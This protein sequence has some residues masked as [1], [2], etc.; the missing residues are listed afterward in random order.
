MGTP[1]VSVW[2]EFVLDDLDVSHVGGEDAKWEEDESKSSLPNLNL[3]W[4][5]ESEN[6]IEP[7]VSEDRPCYGDT[8]HVQMLLTTDLSF[9]NND[10]TDGNDH[11]QIE[12]G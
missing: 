6:Q 5:E 3:S 9:W 7:Y 11:E 12:S 4:G 10:D 8:E 1:A 2:Q